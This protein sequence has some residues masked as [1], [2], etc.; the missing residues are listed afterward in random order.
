MARRKATRLSP[1]ALLRLRSKLVQEGYGNFLFSEDTLTKAYNLE[2]NRPEDTIENRIRPVSDSLLSIKN[3]DELAERVKS[4]LIEGPVVPI[5]GSYYM[6]RYMAKTPEIKFDLNP[7]VQVTEV[8]SYGFIAYNFHWGRNRKYTY[9]EVQGG[10]YE[11]TA[12]E[13]K[14]LELIP[15]QNF[16]M[17]PPK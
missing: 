1:K 6:F 2:T 15:F 14:D 7:L 10:L 5:P 12:D 17:K 16:Q 11:V 9:P 3:P 4:V 13:L 8:F